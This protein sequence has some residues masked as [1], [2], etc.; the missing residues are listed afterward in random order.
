VAPRLQS[1]ASACGWHLLAG[2][3]HCVTCFAW[4]WGSRP[5]R[6]PPRPREGQRGA[7]RHRGSSRRSP[8]HPYPISAAS[9]NRE[10]FSGWES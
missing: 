8:G 3:G 9:R 10:V 4:I 1:C 7:R 6:P 5:P 2:N